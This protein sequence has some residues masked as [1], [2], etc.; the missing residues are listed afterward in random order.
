[1]ISRNFMEV[2]AVISQLCSETDERM[3]RRAI[4]DKRVR[5][6]EVFRQNGGRIQQA[7]VHNFVK[8]YKLSSYEQ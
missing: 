8:I 5:L 1:M 6:Q 3:W 7:L 2:R 4:T